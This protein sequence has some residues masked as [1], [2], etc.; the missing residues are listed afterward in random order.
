MAPTL[1]LCFAL[2]AAEPPPQQRLQDESARTSLPAHIDLV[3]LGPE[4]PESSVVATFDAQ[5]LGETDRNGAVELTIPAGRGHF[6]L[7]RGDE[8]LLDLDLLTEAEE[9]IQLV[10][11]LVSGGEPEVMIETSGEDSILAG[12]EQGTRKPR[13]HGPVKRGSLLGVV[14]SI[15]NGKPV[16]G[17]QVFFSGQP[18][19]LETD[20]EGRFSAELPAGLY[21]VSV[22]DGRYASQ[23]L[24]NVRVIG[25]RE[26]SL[27][28]ELTPAGI[29]L[30]DY[31]V[32]APY[33]EGSVSSVIEQQRNASGVSDVLG[34]AQFR[35][36]GDS[37]A[38]SALTRVTG[39]TVEEGKFV[40]VRGQPA[41]FTLALF[42]GSPLP[43]PE[44]LLRVVPLDLFPTG[45]LKDIQVQKS[46]TPDQPGDFGAGLVQL[47]TRGIP[48]ESF[49]KLSLSTGANSI[50]TLRD[51]LDYE[52]GDTDWLGR[53]DGTRAL[54]KPVR[55]ASNNGRVSLDDLP[56]DEKSAAAQSFSNI[57]E[58]RSKTLPPDFGVGISAGQDFDLPEGGRAG[59]VG[60]LSW[61]NQWRKQERL[62]RSFALANDELRIRNDVI[63]F[64]TDNDVSLSGLVTGGLRY[65]NHEVTVNTF[66]VNQ[67]QQRT[68]FTEGREIGSDQLDVRRTLLSWIER[69]LWAQQLTAHHDFDTL[70]VDLRGLYA[71]AKRDA[72]DRREYEFSKT[73]DQD[74][75]FVRDPGGLLRGYSFV[76]DTQWSGGVDITVPLRGLDGF[77]FH[78]QPKIGV[79]YAKS[80]RDAG[81]QRFL[82]RPGDGV[83]R[84]DPIAEEIFDPAKTGTELGLR[85]NS[86]LGADDYI[87]EAE[88]AAFY[89]MLDLRVADLLRFTGGVRWESARYE[90]RTFQAAD[91]GANTTDPVGFDR[92]N[93]LPAAAMTWFALDT[94]QLR[95]AYGRT[96][97]RPV[98]NE[99]STSFFF[100][101]DSGQ[102]FQGNPNLVPTVI[103]GYDVRA[104]WYPTATESATLGVFVKKYTDPLERT[105]VAQ[106]GGGEIAT[107]QNASEAEVRGLELGGRMEL[108]RLRKWVGAPGFLD[109]FYLQ[110]NGALMTSTVRLSEQGIATTQERPLDG[111][112]DVVLNAQAGYDGED[113]DVTVAFNRIG[114]RLRRAGI[115]SQP[116]IFQAPIATLDVTWIWELGRGLSLQVRGKN[117]LDPEILLTQALEGGEDQ[118]FRSFRRGR[119]ISASLSWEL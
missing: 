104:E 117:L 72:P 90:V 102:Q 40:L 48:D 79:S 94:L 64:R 12:E 39:L 29:R 110:V 73:P 116:N 91:G 114:R 62:Q 10:V 89:A 5:V 65:D 86:I 111:Q 84:A 68:Q 99:L 1:A 19:Q 93:A 7:R 35:A 54:P 78:P 70:I 103:D 119:G 60:A 85:D 108:E 26:V 59:V 106:G 34:A 41:R 113:H 112:A 47:N 36:T 76:N 105:F 30:E 97:S 6:V 13:E 66:V 80:D 23:T 37:N 11:T 46:F 38:A 50:S 33:I 118:T 31:V 55:R 52:G 98:F 63:E 88:I 8:V 77:L 81:E 24:D 17:A 82:F 56:D 9:I 57:L 43:S 45:V 53:D 20:D 42:N 14:R 83:S 15:E 69:F 74:R 71:I 22:V 92:S 32:T 27:E 67:A 115:L 87:G 4:G 21:S 96:V 101:P 109:D 28:I 95:A 107:F 75:Y 3:V 51:G 16:R 100:D 44:P 58:A 61:S 18:G 2:L 25:E 49:L